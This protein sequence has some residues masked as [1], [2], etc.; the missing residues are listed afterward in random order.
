VNKNDMLALIKKRR[1]IRKYT[2][3]PVTDRQI[4]QLLEA[5]MAAPSGSNIQPWDFVVVRDPD[6]KRQLAQTHTWSYMAADATVVFVVCTNQSASGHWLED[7]SAATQN[8]LLAV[9]ALG[10]GAVWV[11]IYPGTDRK[12]HVRQVLAIPDEIRVLCLV[13]VGHPAESKPPRTQYTK[14]ARFTTRGGNTK[15]TSLPLPELR[16]RRSCG[17][18]HQGL[19][20]LPFRLALLLLR[21]A[22]ALFF[23]QPVTQGGP[24]LGLH[25][26]SDDVPVVLGLSASPLT[27]TS[28][29][30]ALNVLADL[31]PVS[32]LLSAG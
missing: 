22:S 27:E 12:A 32:F 9:T 11:G 26:P 31:L 14:R 20:N 30:L 29:H 21:S 19:T 1:S 2:D 4:R 13:P 23:A 28:L 17:I 7:A 6:L 18:A 15:P 24:Y 25:F 16:V 3:Q 8:L 10:L 5:A